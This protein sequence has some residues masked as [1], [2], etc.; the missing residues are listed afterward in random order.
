MGYMLGYK[1]DGVYR[2]WIPKMGVR[3]TRDVVF[4]EGEAPMTPVDGATVEDRREVQVRLNQLC[5]LHPPPRPLPHTT[6]SKNMKQRMYL[7]P[8]TPKRVANGSIRIPPAQPEPAYAVTRTTTR[9]NMSAASTGF[10]LGRLAQASCATQED[11]L[12]GLEPAFAPTPTTPYPQTT[13]EALD[14]ND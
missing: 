12:E 10:Q 8:R 9:P 6:E 13:R 14:V 2:V 1:Y 7:T 4:Y 11:L 3:E 5:R